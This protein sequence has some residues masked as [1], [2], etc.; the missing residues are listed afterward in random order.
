MGVLTDYFVAASD[1]DA[2]SYLGGGVTHLEGALEGKG[3]EPFVMLTTLE[4]LLTGRLYEEVEANGNGDDFYVADDSGDVVVTN[5]RPRLTQVLASCTAQELDQVAV[6]W[7]Q[8]EELTGADPKALADFLHRL[9]DLARTA[10]E[11]GHQVYC[12]LSL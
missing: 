4:A 6:P 12:K 3:I 8:S 10:A 2:G 11:R 5:V 1:K 9:A 7:S